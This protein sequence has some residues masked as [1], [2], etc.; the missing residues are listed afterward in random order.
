M[1]KAAQIWRL[2]A[3]KGR[4][5]KL[6]NAG[7]LLFGIVGDNKIAGNREDKPPLMPKFKNDIGAYTHVVDIAYGDGFVI[8]CTATGQVF[9]Q[10]FSKYFLLHLCIKETPDHLEGLHLAS[11]VNFLV[12]RSVTVTTLTWTSDCKVT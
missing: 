2:Q 9:F 5:N 6:K 8:V 11:E 10:G 7:I 1:K 12:A 3:Q 4:Q